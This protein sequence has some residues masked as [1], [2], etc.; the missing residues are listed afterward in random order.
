MGLTSSLTGGGGGGGG[1]ETLAQTLAL[2]AATGGTDLTVSSG[3][4]LIL[5]E[6]AALGT[7]SAG[8]GVV[9]AKSDGVPYWKDD[10]GTETS[11]LGGGTTPDLATV[12]AVANVTGGADISITSGDALTSVAGSGAGA[13]AA[14]PITAGAGGATGV[15]GAITVTTGAGGATS[16]NSGALSLDVG[17]VVSG[18]AGTISVGVTSA[19]ALTIGRAGVTTTLNGSVAFGDAATARTNLG[20][21]SIATQAASS[22]SITGGAISGITDLAV[23]DGGTGSSTASDARTALGLAIGTDVQAYAANLGAIAALAVTDGNVIVGNGSTW[24]AESGATARTSLGLAIGTDVQ[25]YATS[26]LATV[27]AVGATTGGVDLN[28][29]DGDEITFATTPDTYVGRSAAGIVGIGTAT[30]NYAS[31]KFQCGGIRDGGG[32]SFSFQNAA[33]S[34]NFFSTLAFGGTNA[35]WAVKNIGYYAWSS[36]ANSASTQDT[37]LLR[38]SAGFVQ[39]TG[40]NNGGGGLRTSSALLTVASSA[41][42]SGLIPAGAILLSVTVRVVTLVTGATTFDVGDGSDVD[43]F[44][45]A[46]AVAAN[47][48]TTPAAYTADPRTFSTSAQE[49]TLTPNGGAFT[50]GTVRVNATFF[51]ATGATS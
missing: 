2:G 7:P 5:T 45:A 13:G 9:Y 43:R 40:A 20:L 14:L 42:T 44:G 34:T 47:T 33:G 50:G 6:Q 1:G 37:K 10:A 41:T 19:S 31:G 35:G 16:G 8:T 48:T 11:L 4:G 51:W 3:D 24:V 38:P 17:A 27:L 12:L 25:G 26:T 22:V 23:A 29:G 36:G 21:G 32:G 28:V 30:G 15:G 18:T 39:V 49:V 46:I